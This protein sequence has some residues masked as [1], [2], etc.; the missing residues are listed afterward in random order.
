M[1]PTNIEKVTVK[2]NSLFLYEYKLYMFRPISTNTSKEIL[3]KYD[4]RMLS[5]KGL[6]HC[7]NKNKSR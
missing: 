6:K 1:F 3:H 7:F 2:G 5:L 4:M